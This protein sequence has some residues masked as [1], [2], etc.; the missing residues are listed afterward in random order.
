MSL[1]LSSFWPCMPAEVRRIVMTSPIK[2]C[3][4]DSVPT[5]LVHEFIDLLLPYITSR[6]NA[7]S[8]DGRLF[9]SQKQAIVSPLLKKPGLDVADIAN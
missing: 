7:S 3:C 8:A 1:T 6:V 4:L 5:F 9:D 2:S